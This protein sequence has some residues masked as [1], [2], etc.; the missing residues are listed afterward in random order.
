MRLRPTRRHVLA[1]LAG[2]SLAAPYIGRARAADDFI[3]VNSWGGTWLEAA[4]KNLFDPFTKATGIRVET[5]SPVSY[6]KLV[7][8]ARTKTYDFDVTTLGDPAL[9]QAHQAGVLEPIAGSAFDQSKVPTGNVQYDSVASHV[10]SFNVVY[11]NDINPA[12]PGPQDW[13]ELWDVKRFPGM[14]TLPA[15]SSET[16]ILALLAD[17]VTQANLYPLDLDRAFASLDRIKPHVR[18]FWQ[19]G[20]NAR[21][22]IKDKEVAAGG[23]WAS[24]GRTLGDEGAPITLVRNQALLERAFWVV[25]K[26]TPRAENAWKF[27]QFA[28]SPEPMASFCRDAR[29]GPMD[30]RAFKFIDQKDAALMPTYPEHM[31]TAVYW[32]DI[33]DVGSRLTEM[34]KRFDR[35]VAG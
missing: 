15:Y 21:Q 2:A 27:I 7:A 9:F 26:G 34:T 22:L 18:V 1:G 4:R 17:G 31:K 28:T 16:I 11:R 3:S 30:E 12:G 10:F 35:W 29:M 14:R 23:L 6:A 25:S 32:Q 13:A 19:S 8:Q 33:A 20:A 5:V 24:D